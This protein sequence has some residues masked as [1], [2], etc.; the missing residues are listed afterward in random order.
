MQTPSYQL[1]NRWLDAALPLVCQSGWTSATLAG[2]ARAAGLSEGEQALAAPGGVNDLLD[3]YFLR[4]A[5]R[6]AT[7]LA[8]QDLSQQ[9][10]HEKV[11]T[12]L[13]AWL[14]QMEADRDAVAMAAHRGL[15]PWAAGRAVRCTWSISDR[16]WTAAGDT[17]TDYNRQTKRGLLC[18]VI[19]PII[20]YWIGAPE[21]D[22]LKAYI[23]QRLKQ[24]MRV[25]QAGSQILGP[26]LGALDRMRGR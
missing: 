20:L 5:D 1:R 8:D 25:G 10:T 24:A 21:E 18:A 12:A 14:G 22:A 16:I 15:M 7:A 17:A 19:P 9:R 6:M 23:E 4:A 26:L 13:F 3:H 11:A 2:A